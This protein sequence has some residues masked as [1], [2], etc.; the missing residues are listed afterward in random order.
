MQSKWVKKYKLTFII[1]LAGGLLFMGLGINYIQRLRNALLTS[2]ENYKTEIVRLERENLRLEKTTQAQRAD[3][4][5]NREYVTD[6]VSQNYLFEANSSNLSLNT[7]A[8]SGKNNADALRFI[9]SGHLYGSADNEGSIT[10]SST[11]IDAVTEINTRDPDLFFTLG[12]LTYAP[13]AQSFA[14]LHEN[15]LSKVDAPIFNAPGNHDFYNGRAFYEE[16]FG[17]SFYYFKYGQTQIIILDTEVGQCAILGRQKEMLS[18][19]LTLALDDDDISSIFIFFH[20]TLF[21][22]GEPQLMAQAND[23]CSYG[24]NYGELEAEFFIPAAQKKPLY[25]IAGDVGAFGGNLSP[26]YYKNPDAN[27]YALA[28]GLGDSPDDLLLQIDILP[29]SEIELQIIS[30]GGNEF[31]EI[32]TYTPEY[33]TE[34]NVS[35]QP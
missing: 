9:I 1:V 28:L 8:V 25:L 10:P 29:S 11:L 24:T 15:F 17:Q 34:K 35:V 7:L 30:I 12:D 4:I 3:I 26:F 23:T 33:W 14:E 22:E 13:S 16:A 5:A 20:K 21:L 31:S 27:L 19:A 2:T 32:E 6:G 18:Q